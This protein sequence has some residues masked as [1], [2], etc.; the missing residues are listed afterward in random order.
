MLPSPPSHPKP[1]MRLS[2][3]TATQYELPCYGSS[4]YRLWQFC[5]FRTFIAQISRANFHLQHLTR[6]RG[7]IQE[8]SVLVF[9]DFLSPYDFS[10][11]INSRLRTDHLHLSRYGQ[12]FPYNFFPLKKMTVQKI[13]KEVKV[14]LLLSFD[15]HDANLR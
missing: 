6:D 3:H 11:D 13:V 14:F 15:S 4:N 9:A 10:T 8:D 1:Y 5:D 7:G 12:V 2:P